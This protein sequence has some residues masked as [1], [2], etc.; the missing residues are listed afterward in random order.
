MYYRFIRGLMLSL[1]LIAILSACGVQGSRSERFDRVHPGMTRA[2]LI[3]LLGAP[4]LRGFDTQSETLTYASRSLTQYIRRVIRLESGVVVSMRNEV[5]EINPQHATPEPTRP[6]IIA[7]EERPR[8]DRPY[9][10]PPVI[11]SEQEEWFED[12]MRRY[13]SATFSSDKREVLNFALRNGTFSCVQVRR[14]MQTCTFDSEK[15]E[16]LQFLAPAIYDPHN[17][18]RIADMFTFDSEKRRAI[19]IIEG[20]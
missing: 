18:Y 1:A 15:W 8:Y 2:E 14:L 9:S 19:Q 3:A 5:E 17:A 16:M 20:R 12:L 11:T 4:S 7:P 10:R 13:N 6:I